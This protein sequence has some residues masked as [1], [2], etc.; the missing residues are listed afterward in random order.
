MKTNL[1]TIYTGSPVIEI[2]IKL[3]NFDSIKCY[4]A[5]DNGGNIY[6]AV[7]YNLDSTIEQ[8]EEFDT[9]VSEQTQELINEA[10]EIQGYVTNSD[11]FKLWQVQQYWIQSNAGVRHNPLY[12]MDA[13]QYYPCLAAIERL[14]ELHKL[15][16]QMADMESFNSKLLTYIRSLNPA[17]FGVKL[18]TAKK[19]I[20][21]IINN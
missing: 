2:S 4:A 21:K 10:S 9:I 15:R 8:V 20:L 14:E 13:S 1:K 5:L 12:K 7:M 19:R 6:R 3:N 18:S 16:K 11:I 17:K